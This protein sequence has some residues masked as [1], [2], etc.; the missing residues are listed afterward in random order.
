MR[1]LLKIFGSLISAVV[2]IVIVIPVVASILL[3]SHR[4]QNFV[5]DRF[6]RSFSE[7]LGTTVTLDRINIR[8]FNRVVID[9][10]YVQDL[11]GDTLLYAGTLDAGFKGYNL[12]TGTLR[13]GD[14]SIDSAR[15]YVVQDST[16]TSNLSYI[17]RQLKSKNPKEEKKDFLLRAN[18]LKITN[19]RFRL[20][21]Y[22]FPEKPYGVNFADLDVRDINLE[23]DGI[24]LINDSINTRIKTIAFREKSG[25]VLDNLSAGHARVSR[26]GIILD[27]FRLT[28]PYSDLRMSELH[29]VYP[30]W[31][32]FRDF[33]EKVVF[34]AVPQQSQVA[35]RTIGYFAPGL[36]EWQSVVKLDGTI[37]GP[38]AG[39]YGRFDDAL[40]GET[41]LDTDYRIVGLPDI[42]RTRFTLDVHELSGDSEEL[43]FLLSEF[44][45][46]L[47][48]EQNALLERLDAVRLTGHFDGLLSD[49]RANGSVVTGPGNANFNVRL[50]PDS[51]GRTYLSGHV[52]ASE[53]HL[54]QLLAVRGLGNVSV[55]GDL[56]GF[57]GSDSLDLQIDAAVSELQYNTYRYQHIDIDGVVRNSFYQ[58]YVGSSDPNIDFT[59]NGTFDFNREIPQ[60]DFTLD[61]KRIDLNALGINPRDSI[62]ILSGRIEANAEG[63]RIDDI[64]GQ[65]A[66]R[67][68]VYYFP[69]DTL[70]SSEIRLVG[71]NLS[72]TKTVGFYS[73]FAD[74]ELRSRLN[75]AD[76]VPYVKQTLR[77][78]LPSLD[79]FNQPDTRIQE[80]V[81]S[82][83]LIS[84]ENYYLVQATVKETGKFASALLPGLYVEEGT[85]FSFLLNPATRN[86]SLVLDSELIEY[87]NMYASGINLTNRNQAD[88]IAIYLRTEETGIGNFFMPQLSV[89]GGVKDNLVNLSAG[90]TNPVNNMSAMLN[91]VSRLT[92]DSLAQS[93]RWH[94]RFYSSSIQMGPD[95]WRIT[96]PGI[97][98]GDSLIVVDQ[99]RIVNVNANPE[100]SG[101]R[102]EFL[103]DGRVSPSQSDTL[104]LSMVNF[105]LSPLS[106]IIDRY[107]YNIQGRTNGHADLIGG[108]GDPLFYA[109]IGFENMEINDKPVQNS[110]FVSEWDPEVERI[111]MSWTLEKGDSILWGGYRPGDQRYY[112]DARIPNIDLDHLTPV[113][114]SVLTD[115]SGSADANL[116]I[117]GAGGGPSLNG[118]LD[119][120]DFG[121]TVDFTKVRYGFQ[122]ATAQVVNNDLILTDTPIYDPEGG[123]GTLNARLNTRNFSNISYDVRVHTDQIL[124]LNTTERD[125]DYFYGK[126]YA[127]GSVII[128][129]ERNR[130]NMEMNLT[131][132]ANSAFYMPLSGSSTIEEADFIVFEDPN[133]PVE[134]EDIPRYRLRQYLREQRRNNPLKSD[135]N[136][137][138]HLN[139]NPGMDVQLVIDPKIGDVIRAN[140]SGALT[141]QIRP[142][143]DIFNMFGDYQINEGSYLFTL[144]NILNKRFTIE[145]GSSIL[146]VGDPLDAILN[147]TATYRVR[148][149]VS[150][151]TG[152]MVNQNV[153]VDCKILLSD[154]LSQPTI[155]FDI[156]VPTVDAETRSTIQNFMNTQELK[157][158]Q[159]V[160]LLMSNSFYVESGLSTGGNIG[161]TTT[162]VTGIEFLT[163]QL[164]NW[165]ST[166]RFMFNLGYTPRSDMSSDEVEGMFTGELIPNKLILE[167]EINYNFGNNAADLRGDNQIAG[168]FALTY[169]F[170]PVG[171]LRAKVFTRT[172]DRYDENQ[173]L[174]EQ[175]VGLYYRKD[176]NS[177]R[178]LFRRQRPNLLYVPPA[179]NSDSEGEEQ[180]DEN[181]DDR[182]QP[183]NLNEPNEE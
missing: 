62:S 105:D 129:G 21:R 153:P 37:D 16:F 120:R 41:R 169:V 84:T 182:E 77:Y 88:S 122:Q 159:F 180:M 183:A 6:T 63:T 109:R 32:A 101:N 161:T 116:V 144:M 68:L 47:D 137:N 9:G 31:N 151:I 133:R 57:M 90:F 49:F 170:D 42:D 83:R 72:D 114:G 174:Q 65:G 50:S 132:T 10:L 56:N 118:T 164:S 175:G 96:G 126:V 112:F 162:T 22:E 166:D 18:N 141:L 139:V 69:G 97:S 66:I 171:N 149:S 3:S 79:P 181:P 165:I 85:T 36:K 177:W 81:D 11:Q 28:A 124:G 95:Q 145:R 111:R 51:L 157:S 74:I 20:Q 45:K 64:T 2:L 167:G 150:Q 143:E 138:M 14:V 27:E 39:L 24:N 100:Q 92:V 108:S 60:Y 26:T 127:A 110:L 146:W 87:N 155:N 142:R 4:I 147:V 94:S 5:A 33:T 158:Q 176:F 172:I 8:L 140:G 44:V 104:H 134:V 128:Q 106:G 135:L 58:G 7:K 163:N 123:G 48:L 17:T 160:W 1:K 89:Q 98:W 30:A 25:F 15:F 35:F 12:R 13:L 178:N 70:R 152:G 76:I 115:I 73:D 130:V 119:I 67:D 38:V 117:T 46:D 23:F 121:G 107:G 55:A 43:I 168:D 131:N 103:L 59:L 125:N 40:I 78:Y 82:A 29:L 102:Q 19:T 53:F 173:G 93:S 113:L 54:G 136:I 99:F 80:Q 61:A 71:D 34:H 91:T 75:I 148:A 179:T 154:R 156:E 86:F 52:A